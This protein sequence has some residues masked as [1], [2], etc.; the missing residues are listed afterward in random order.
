MMVFDIKKIYVLININM[1]KLT[2]KQIFEIHEKCVK[3]VKRKPAEFF[4]L[5]KMK[6]YE[7]SC[8]WTDIDL[9]YRGEIL[10]TAYH[11][12]VHYLY[13]DFSEEKVAYIEKR[14]VNVCDSFEISYFL[15]LLANKL[16]KSELQKYILKDKK[17]RK[18]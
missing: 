18:K 8:N 9:D 7:G 16:Y 12:C 2:K 17:N 15:K 6:K 5:K 3:L 13:P 11:E 1:K 4:N 10:S 14:I